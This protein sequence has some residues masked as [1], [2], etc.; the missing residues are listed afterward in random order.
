MHVNVNVKACLA[1]MKMAR[2]KKNYMLGLKS[3]L[4]KKK[5]VVHLRLEA[6]ISKP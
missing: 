5:Q 2:I 6:S 3:L 4:L 1:S